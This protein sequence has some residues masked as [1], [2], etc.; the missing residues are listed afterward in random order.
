MGIF[1][2]TDLYPTEDNR[3]GISYFYEN[4]ANDMTWDNTGTFSGQG[5]V[6]DVSGVPDILP[7]TTNIFVSLKNRSSVLPVVPCI[8]KKAVQL[9]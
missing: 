2:L 7:N 6:S 4:D 3:R 8:R 9:G 1:S 5:A